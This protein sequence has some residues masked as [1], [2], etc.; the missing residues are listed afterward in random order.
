M[1]NISE[2]TKAILLLT[3]PLLLKAVSKS[4]TQ[5]QYDLLKPTEYHQLAIFLRDT[6][7]Q[8]ANLLTQEAE[9]ILDEYGKLD[10]NRVLALL[11]RGFLLSQVLDYWQSRGIWVISRADK[12]YPSRF[13]SRLKEHSPAILYG[14][15]NLILL[16]QG[17]LAIVGSRNINDELIQ[18]TQAVSSSAAQ[19]GKMVI[20]GGAKGV[21][22]TAM[23]SALN[24]GGNVCGVL[25]DSLEK[26]ALN[27]MNRQA[28]QEERLV[29]ISACD[30]KS[31]FNVGNAMQRNKYIYALSDAA[32]VVNSDLKKGGTWAGAVEQLEKFKC[33]PIYI[34][35]VG[36]KSEGLDALQNKGARL[37]S[38]PSSEQEWND[39]TQTIQVHSLTLDRGTAELQQISLFN[40]IDEPK[41]EPNPLPEQSNVLFNTVK[42]LVKELILQSPKGDDELAVALDVSKSQMKSWLN[43]LIQENA[44]I[45]KNKPIR[46]MW[47]SK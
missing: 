30:P 40:D 44:V 46:Y 38:N 6:K 14:C 12:Y 41:T 17:G 26:A 36:Q 32:L 8:P 47:N 19:A 31:G 4:S 13:K 35:A 34:R 21:D 18:Y 24:N 16:E 25:A 28:L 22:S 10:K 11:G 37:W 29:L 42:S 9:L 23:Y 27:A 33:I 5:P 7:R 20:S 45:K 43:R 2:N 39:I 1:M 15:G 3:A